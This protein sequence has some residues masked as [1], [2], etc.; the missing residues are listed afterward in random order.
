MI[1]SAMGSGTLT[2]LNADTGDVITRRKGPGDVT[3][4]NACNIYVCYKF[5]IYVSYKFTGEV[6]GLTKDL[7]QEKILLSKPVASSDSLQCFRSPAH[8][9]ERV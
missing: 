1:V 8:R 7:P 4:D 3:T 5:T 2:V 9:I 6:A